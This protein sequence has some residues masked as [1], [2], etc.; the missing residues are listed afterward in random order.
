MF[1]LNIP[2]NSNAQSTNT[3]EL[4]VCDEF[5]SEQY[6]NDKLEEYKKYLSDK[7]DE[8]YHTTLNKLS[9]EFREKYKHDSK[10]TIVLNVQHIGYVG[11][12]VVSIC[13]L[14]QKAIQTFRDV[15]SAK[16]FSSSLYETT[17][18]TADQKIIGYRSEITVYC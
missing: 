10:D 15:L 2:W 3:K 16:G 14:K 4:V 1:R 12:H 13:V 5:D 11:S 9:D 6:I 8:E 18:Y 17:D 7:V